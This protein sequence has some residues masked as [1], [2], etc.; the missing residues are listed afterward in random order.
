MRR[1]QRV[2]SEIARVLSRIIDQE[3]KDPRIGLV[4]ILTVDVSPDLKNA[5]V[6]FSSFGDKKEIAKLLDGAKGF[7]RKGLANE[8]R[9][10]I[11]PELRF[12][13][14][15]SYEYG[16]RIDQLFEKIKSNDK[17]EEPNSDRNPH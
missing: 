14:D 6:Y 8:I 13:I 12:I 17:K 11:I 15:E 3:L 1:H 16:K 2:A 10:R 9:I 7:I 4:T 5:N